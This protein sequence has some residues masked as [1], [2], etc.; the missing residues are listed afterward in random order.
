MSSEHLTSK[1][2]RSVIV[3]AKAVSLCAFRKLSALSPCWSHL[4]VF[5]ALVWLKFSGSHIN[6]V[7]LDILMLVD[8]GLIDKKSFLP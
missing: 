1:S 8:G 3:L 5:G 7:C 6:F 4:N 2:K